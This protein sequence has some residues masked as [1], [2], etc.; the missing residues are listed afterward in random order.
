MWRIYQA[1]GNLAA[2]PGTS[3]HGA[4]IAVDVATPS[5]RAMIDHIGARYGW[6][7]RTS[8]APSEWWHLK[9][10]EGSWHGS[11][12]GPYGKSIVPAIPEPP[13]GAK[14]IHAVVKQSG[15]IELFCEVDSGSKK[16]EIF[17]TWQNGPNSSTWAA[18]KSLGNPSK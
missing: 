11:D 4:G 9:W 7:K 12:P 8:D 13:E 18:W 3:N 5:M 6:E 15:A 17:H 2:H 1:G 10:R 14:M 16:G